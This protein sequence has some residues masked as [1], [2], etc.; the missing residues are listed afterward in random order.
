M[1]S[2]HSIG[3]FT[4]DETAHSGV[5]TRNGDIYVFQAGLGSETEVLRTVFH[6]L[7][8]KGLPRMAEEAKAMTEG[9]VAK[10]STRSDKPA[11]PLSLERTQQLVQQALAGILNTPPVHTVL[12]AAGGTRLTV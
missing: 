10:F 3:I 8:H 9:G 7:F 4:D 5:T 12:S 2:P 1:R 11:A 6:E